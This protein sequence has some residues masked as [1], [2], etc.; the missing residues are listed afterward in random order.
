MTAKK[1][2]TTAKG[3]PNMINSDLKKETIKMSI[4]VLI[5]TAIMIGVFAALGRFDYKVVTGGLLGAVVTIANHFFLAFSV[6][7]ISGK[8]SVKDGQNLMKLS[9]FG[10][11]VLIGVAV[12]IAIKLPVFNYI[13]TA[14]PLLFPRV[15]I[16]ILNIF[17]S[18]K[19]RKA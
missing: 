19:D 17:D 15:V 10:R 7:R 9:Y 1:T 18:R 11:L 5:M 4:G 2:K 16:I 14:I 13:A 3:S 6:E 8:E 12:F